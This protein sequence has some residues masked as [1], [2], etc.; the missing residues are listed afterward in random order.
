M[1]SVLPA[2]LCR[3]EDTQKRCELMLTRV[4]KESEAQ[5]SCAQQKSKQERGG[6]NMQRR[7]RERDFESQAA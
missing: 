4:Q 6:A 1:T 2:S 7:C 5:G 3:C